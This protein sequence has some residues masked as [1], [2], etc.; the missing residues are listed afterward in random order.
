M[1]PLSRERYP[2][3]FLALTGRYTMLQETALRLQGLPEG[4]DVLAPIM[5]CNAEKVFLLRKNESTYIPLGHVH[6]LAN[7]GK[8][9][10]ELI[11]VHSGRYLGEDDIVRFEDTYRRMKPAAKGGDA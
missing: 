2:K 4:V 6:R 7:S 11:E 10:L 5:V 9:P 1:W 3:Q 8:V